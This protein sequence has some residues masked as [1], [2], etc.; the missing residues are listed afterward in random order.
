[1]D[2]ELIARLFEIA[3]EHQATA[4]ALRLGSGGGSNR[5]TRRER[6][7]VTAS[8]HR[9][10]PQVRA[11]AKTPLRIKVSALLCECCEDHAAPASMEAPVGSL[12][13]LPGS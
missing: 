13:A 7:G 4:D 9:D 12:T 1:M 6:A 10:W 2:A 3:N 11:T 8:R 5:R